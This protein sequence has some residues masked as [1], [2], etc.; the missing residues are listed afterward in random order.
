[1]MRKWATCRRHPQPLTSGYMS[2][3]SILVEHKVATRRFELTVRS[4][5]DGCLSRS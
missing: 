3:I 4:K 2:L 1:M 5:V